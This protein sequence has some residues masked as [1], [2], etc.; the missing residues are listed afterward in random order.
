M[1]IFK[2][3]R[4]FINKKVLLEKSTR[5]SSHHVKKGLEVI[6]VLLY[7]RVKTIACGVVVGPIGWLTFSLRSSRVG[8]INSK[9]LQTKSAPVSNRSQ[10]KRS[11]EKV[12]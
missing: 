5:P 7:E 11:R 9:P 12:R 4:Y 3:D 8:F 1:K 10:K 2:L 6:K